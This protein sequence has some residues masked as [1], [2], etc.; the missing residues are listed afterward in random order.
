MALIILFITSFYL[1]CWFEFVIAVNDCVD[2]YANCRLVDLVF[3]I[4]QQCQVFLCCGVFPVTSF[5]WLSLPLFV[6]VSSQLQL[7]WMHV[8]NCHL[9]SCVLCFIGAFA[10]EA[11]YRGGD[12]PLLCIPTC[13][14]CYSRLLLSPL[15]MVT[16]AVVVHLCCLWS[17][18]NQRD[19]FH[20]LE[21]SFCIPFW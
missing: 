4:Y 1:P 8:L 20:V 19:P 12:L 13:M 14:K 21:F 3:T 9:T 11:I 6:A 15:S 16:E 2:V 7:F 17:F 10:P 5:V 18:I